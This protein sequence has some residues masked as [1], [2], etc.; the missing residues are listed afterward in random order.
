LRYLSTRGQAPVLDF[1]GVLLD[2]LAPD[3]G[4]YVPET[5]PR[6]TP[7]FLQECLAQEAR[8][9]SYADVAV[10][11]MQPFVGDALDAGDFR[12][13]V[14]D[15]YQAFDHPDV[16]PLRPLGREL[17]GILGPSHYLL[18]LFH[19][20]TLAFKDIA[21]QLLARLF[22]HVLA[23]RN[24]RMTVLGATSGD[25][26]AAAISAIRGRAAID[27]FILHPKDRV[28]AV[29]RRQM[30]TV[31]DKNVRNIAIEGTFDDCQALVK[32][33]FQDKSMRQK[34]N[35]GAINSINWARVMA[36]IVY[37]VTAWVAVNRGAK[38]PGPVIF[39]VP[40]GNFGDAYAGFAAAKM[41]LP[42]AK[43]IVATNVNDILARFFT[44]GAY[45]LGQVQPTFSPAM[46][47]Q[48]ASNF[49]RLLFDLTGRSS[50]K[51][52]RLMSEL[53]KSGGFQIEPAAL[54]QAQ[55][56][57]KG[58]RVDEAQTLAAIAD[59]FR[60]HG[61]VLDPHTAVAYAAAVRN[62]DAGAPVVTLATAHP[63]K[64]APA[65]SKAL[66]R[67]P[68]MPQT[69]EAVLSLEERYVILPNDFDALRH[70]IGAE[71]GF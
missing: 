20:P 61:V 49:E 1:E 37:Y 35:L 71:I 9:L 11:V 12:K 66:G 53:E 51:L 48:V 30:T 32:A 24:Q 8:G 5:W 46:D 38:S 58:E 19:G 62:L 45:R 10:R 29:Q 21:L 23:R 13:I 40:S 50:E 44:T 60:S 3:G 33:A 52:L 4:L 31:A 17:G 39:S 64:F 18:E 56:L 7:E 2:G 43:L 59:C 42:V 57:F 69:L 15:A 68:E 28:S 22:D 55:A 16:A 36:Q 41:G 26:G 47:I 70:Y 14:N 34:Y 54:A 67:E 25:T 6:L 63:A 27:I 65:V